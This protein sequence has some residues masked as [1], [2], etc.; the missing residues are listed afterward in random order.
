METNLFTT[1]NEWLERIK[2]GFA[3]SIKS[4][5]LSLEWADEFQEYLIAKY[6]LPVQ[7]RIWFI[8]A[9]YNSIGQDLNLSII[10]IRNC[11][12]AFGRRRDLEDDCGLVLDWRILFDLMQSILDDKASNPEIA[13]QLFP[14]LLRLIDC[15]SRYRSDN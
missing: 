9:F 8:K 11:V 10:F 2:I 1:H 12:Q 15:S 5:H 6:Q 7:E 4:N 3:T 13:S 14:H